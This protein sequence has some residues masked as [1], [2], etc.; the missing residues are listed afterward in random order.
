MKKA[1]LFSLIFVM[2]IAYAAA[3]DCGGFPDAFYGEISI[4]GE[5]APAG[6]KILGVID[7]DPRSDEYVTSVSGYYGNATGQDKLYVTCDETLQVIEFKVKSGGDW[8]KAQETAICECGGFHDLDLTVVTSTDGDGDGYTLADDCDDDNASIN[9][10]AA[11]VCNGAD[12]DCDGDVDEGFA[13]ADCSFV[14]EAEGAAWDD[15]ACC[16][17]DPL[18]GSPFEQEE[19]S[20]EDGNDNDCDGL[21]DIED[22]DCESACADSDGDGFFAIGPGCP[23]G[24]D[25]DD[26]NATINPGAD[27][28]CEDDMDNDCDD[29]VDSDDPEC[30]G[31]CIDSDGDGYFS[32]TP[33]CPSGDDCDD[34]NS[35]I[36]PGTPEVC[37]GADDDCDGDTDENGTMICDDG[38]F[39][40]GAE[41]CGGESGC[42]AGTPVNCSQYSHPEIAQCDHDDN[43]FTWDQ[44]SSFTSVCDEEMDSCTMSE[45]THT[46]D[47]E[48]CGAQCV[49]EYD[50][51][52][53]DCSS[54]D[55]CYNGTYREYNPVLSV[56]E[57]CVCQAGTCDDYS[58]VIT[59]LDGDGYDVE[60]D[61]DCDDSD[62]EMFPGNLEVLDGKDNDCDGMVDENLTE[63]ETDS[64]CDTGYQCVEGFCELKETECEIFYPMV[65]FEGWNMFGLP[66]CVEMD[67]DDAF[68]SID[69]SYV[70]AFSLVNGTWLNYNPSAPQELN[71][72]E[73]L[74]P[75]QG[76]YI[77]MQ[78]NDILIIE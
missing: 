51:N 23:E 35:S 8:V 16:G 41:T 15:D 36:N 2:S 33:E 38:L 11:E 7:D 50:C 21:I 12:D 52:A 34:S 49:D 74:H 28:I 39:C 68:H 14:C 72:L 5:D 17:D 70:E 45:F 66:S 46:C 9:P 61:N 29:L 62:A 6:T 47:I 1:L 56:C 76:V 22:P 25:C 10:G 75:M 73:T 78:G 37:N 3:Y 64:D 53:T 27:E 59:D 67:V 18:E 32:N 63:C 26:S 42:Q 43:P 40:N 65:L 44:S 20:C 19:L 13:S 54:R 4:N 71:T 77:N 58:E 31:D 30:Q 48:N 57:G 24:D 60:C 55:G 69:G